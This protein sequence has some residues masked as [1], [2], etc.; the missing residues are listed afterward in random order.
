MPKAKPSTK[1][2]LITDKDLLKILG[3]H[4]GVKIDR[5]K[6]NQV[7]SFC[8]QFGVDRETRCSKCIFYNKSVSIKR[9]EKDEKNSKN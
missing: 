1:N 4:L 5:K 9:R 7:C 8:T 6:G 2:Y 3:D